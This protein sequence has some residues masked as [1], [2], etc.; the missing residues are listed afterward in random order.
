[1]ADSRPTIQPRWKI[2]FI[3]G[4]SSYNSQQSVFHRDVLYIM[5]CVLYMMIMYYIM[6]IMYS[7]VVSIM[8]TCSAADVDSRS[9]VLDKLGPRLSH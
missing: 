8:G 1:M 5:Y 6:Y 2:D 9:W 4:D 7:L 3:V